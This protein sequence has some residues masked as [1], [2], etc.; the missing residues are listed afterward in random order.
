MI[1][2]RDIFQLK[3]GKARPAQVVLKAGLPLLKKG[4]YVPQRFLTDFS[5]DFYTLIME[6]S[7]KD[8]AEYQRALKANLGDKRWKE[9]YQKF[10][11]L[12]ESG[13]RE[14]LTIVQLK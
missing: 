6:S 5:G 11:P 2:V 3:F 4:G 10:V 7:F 13:R 12:V 14:I 1:L 8:L 9:W